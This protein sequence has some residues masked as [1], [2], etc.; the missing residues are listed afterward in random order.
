[1]NRESSLC[2]APA[3][4]IPQPKS[5]DGRWQRVGDR[6]ARGRHAQKGNRWGGASASAGWPASEHAD[7]NNPETILA[8]RSKIFVFIRCMG[9]A[10]PANRIEGRA[11]LSL[12]LPQLL[13][14]MGPESGSL[15]R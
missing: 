4:L 2:H 9:L 13:N 11:G 5:R 1:M 10:D 7:G 3:V 12:N 15:H 14:L 6:S 8:A